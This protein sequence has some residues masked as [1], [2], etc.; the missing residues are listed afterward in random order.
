M[1]CSN[2]YVYDVVL[3]VYC[4]DSEYMYMY[5]V[6]VRCVCS[7]M[8]MYMYQTTRTAL[9]Y[10]DLELLYRVRGVW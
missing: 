9:C 2:L 3:C 5:L 8:Y 10:S 7:L 4:G 1:Y 6:Y